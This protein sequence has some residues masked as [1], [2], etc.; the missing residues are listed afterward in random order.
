MG[1][2]VNLMSEMQTVFSGSYLKGDGNLQTSISVEHAA[3]H[4]AALSSWSLLLTLMSPGDVYQLL[5]SENR[6]TP[7]LVQLS[8]LLQS[9]HLEVR[10][11]AGEAIALIYELG[12]EFSTDFQEDFTA[13]LVEN[14]RGLATDSHKYR[15]KK[16]RKQ[17]RA[18]FRDILHFIE[19][20][21][22]ERR[23]FDGRHRRL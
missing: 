11:C 23:I 20:N 1:E 19:V 9:P 7:S 16:D 18:T 21:P 4:A 17:Q 13:E 14:L 12:R 8:E 22:T 6:F 15:A 10:L 5:G 2:V 3:L